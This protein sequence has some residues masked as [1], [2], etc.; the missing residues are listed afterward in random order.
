MYCAIHYGHL[1]YEVSV[2][3]L[4]DVDFL[5]RFT[6]NHK[7]GSVLL[8]VFLSSLLLKRLINMAINV[9]RCLY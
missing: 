8:L 5:Q 4:M 3:K 7:C 2:T 6:Y 1:N 9:S